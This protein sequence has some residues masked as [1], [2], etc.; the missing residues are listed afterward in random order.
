MPREESQTPETAA[1]APPPPTMVAVSPH[2]PTPRP[3]LEPCAAPPV[4]PA[5]TATLPA[6]VAAPIT[7]A[8]PALAAPATP[9]AATAATVARPGAPGAVPIPT[10]SRTAAA[11]SGTAEPPSSFS[12]G[13]T[14]ATAFDMA[15]LRAQL[16]SSQVA[17]RLTNH[18]WNS[19]ADSWIQPPYRPP[20]PPQ[21]RPPA[22]LQPASEAAS[23]NSVTRDGNSLQVNPEATA[24]SKAT[25]NLPPTSPLA[26][27]PPP[28]PGT[29]TALPPPPPPPPPHQPANDAGAP[30]VG[31][32][33]A[34]VAAAEDLLAVLQPESDAT[35]L[36]KRAR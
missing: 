1:K 34:M 7:G 26:R 10:A 25:A 22:P 20:L 3:T 31:V 12:S 19:A 32:D 14:A 6:T 27:D 5:P 21:S 28:S 2:N 13:P 24:A 17:E 36:L 4:P 35:V 15:G 30:P 29:A 18:V 11:V 23:G 33:P 8:A 16:N 9:A